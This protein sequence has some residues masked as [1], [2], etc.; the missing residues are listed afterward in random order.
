[1]DPV[2]MNPPTA[3]NMG[4]VWEHQIGSARSIL[5]AL[6]KIYRTE[7]WISESLRTFPAEEEPI[8]NTRPITSQ[9]LSDVYSP[10]P[11]CPMQLLTLKSRV[12]MPPSGEFQKENIY[13]RKQWRSV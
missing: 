3:N 8:V 5:V 10:V 9:S 13:C 7:V 2:E 12:V 1:M 11:L 4:G 6:I